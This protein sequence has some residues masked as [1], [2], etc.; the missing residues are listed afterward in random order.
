MSYNLYITCNI[1]TILPDDF[2]RCLMSQNHMSQSIATLTNF[3]RFLC[4]SLEWSECIV[5]KV[6]M[7]CLC[8]ESHYIS[9]S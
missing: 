6:R 1:W 2:E 8:S 4:V 7:Y 5:Y 3:C 9:D